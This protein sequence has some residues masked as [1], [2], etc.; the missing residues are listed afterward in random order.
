MDSN[1]GAAGQAGE[2][3]RLKVKGME[4]DKKADTGKTARSRKGV[5]LQLFGVVLFSLGLLNTMLTLKGGLEPDRFNYILIILGV[6]FIAS[7]VWQSR[8]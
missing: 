3:V 7:G 5:I 2:A 1:S 4:E 6:V 8:K